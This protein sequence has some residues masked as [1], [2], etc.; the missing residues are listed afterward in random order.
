M[1]NLRARTIGLLW[2]LMIILRAAGCWKLGRLRML[3]ATQISDS[4]APPSAIFYQAEREI[5]AENIPSRPLDEPNTYPRLGFRQFDDVSIT[6]NRRVSSVLSGQNL[7][8]PP[9]ADPGPWRLR[10]GEPTVGGILRQ[11]DNSILL[12]HRRRS[13]PVPKAIFVG[14]WSAHNWFHWL[15]DT[16]PSVFLTRRLPEDFDSYPVL[17]DE[18]ALSRPA[19]LEPLKLII[20]DREIVPLSRDKYITVKD[21]VW[22]DSPTSPG[23]LPQIESGKPSFRL[24]PQAMT[25]FRDHL[26]AELDLQD[27]QKQTHKRVF[28]GRQD[29]SNRPYN[30]DELF[31]EAARFGY[32]TVFLEQLNF[33]DSVKVMLE[34]ESV[35]GPHGAG[36]ANSIFCRP[37]TT[38]V[39]W[40]W[41]DSLRDNWFSNIAQLSEMKFT[42]LVTDDSVED[43]HNLNPG[44]LRR[45]LESLHS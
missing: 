17:L 42:T 36:W 28:L 31:T 25:D 22:I 40:T 14:S 35:I 27:I 15:I 44:T 20:G 7:F 23:P 41:R 33:E 21:L 39:M 8:L 19:W 34:A 32:E 2:Y 37:G 5:R 18:A 43:S 26:I 1:S 11:S 9:S 3:R 12:L 4:N 45:A 30:Q 6:A 29:S 16:L 38:G 24:H 13:K 10:V